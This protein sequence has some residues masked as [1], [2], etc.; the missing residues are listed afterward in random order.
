[1]GMNFN[2][3]DDRILPPENPCE[4]QMDVWFGYQKRRKIY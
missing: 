1:M 2:F 4:A 3:D